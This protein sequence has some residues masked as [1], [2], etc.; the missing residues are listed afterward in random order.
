MGPRS[1]I[2]VVPDFFSVG[3]HPLPV[4]LICGLAPLY[5]LICLQRKGNTPWD[6]VAGAVQCYRRVGSRRLMVCAA[7]VIVGIVEAHHIQSAAG[8]AV[9]RHLMQFLGISLSQ[10]AR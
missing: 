3:A 6:R 4:V 2:R 8:A 1:H 10:T 5:A 9:D 7:L